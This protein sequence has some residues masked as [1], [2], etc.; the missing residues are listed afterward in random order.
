MDKIII[1]GHENPDVDSIVSGYL[2]EKVL[3]IK[4]YSAEFVIPDGKIEQE[5]LDICRKYNLEPTRFKKSID[6]NDKNAQYILVDHDERNVAGCIKCVIDHHPNGKE[7]IEGKYYNKKISSTACY[8]C[9][10]NENLLSK[11]DLLL[12][13]VATMVD[14]ASFNSTK[15]REEDKKWVLELC[16][17]YGFDYDK[18]YKEGLCLTNLDDIQAAS[19]NGLKKYNHGWKK[20]QS[21]YI[22][23]K[24]PMA[25]QEKINEILKILEDYIISQN[26]NAFV[27]IVHDMVQ[28]K[29][30][31][32]LI[33]DGKI[34][35]RDYEKYTSRGNVVVPEVRE[36]LIP[37]TWLTIKKMLDENLSKEAI[38]KNTG[39]S[40]DKIEEFYNNEYRQIKIEEHLQS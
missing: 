30:S 14:T 22:Q 34:E 21:S 17:T 18:L 28:F 31:Y 36:E 20:F 7:N 35:K 10:G 19:L 33:K 6:L 23:V 5:S 11:E 13:A 4:G 16:E 2:L 27:F 15:G 40:E 3:T 26:L 32:Y 39:V 29:T 9:Q 12:A 8:V 37:N 24:D 1:L 25:E 38:S